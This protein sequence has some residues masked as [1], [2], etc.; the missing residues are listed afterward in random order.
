MRSLG[1]ELGTDPMAVY[2]YF[3]GKDEILRNVGAAVYGRMTLP[4]PSAPWQVR[5]R[6]YANHYRDIA[7]A[8]PKLMV[9]LVSNPPSA[10]AAALPLLEFLYAAFADAGLRPRTAAR[11]ADVL[12]DVVN[13][14]AIAAGSGRKMRSRAEYGGVLESL[15]SER[16]PVLRGIL[17]ELDESDMVLDLDRELDFVIAGIEA[18]PRK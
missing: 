5:V 10:V 4:D 11:A 9:Y 7:A 8:Y 6:E 3:S 2:H 14:H 1:A 17:S 15:P 18:V 16:Y 12:I 13:G